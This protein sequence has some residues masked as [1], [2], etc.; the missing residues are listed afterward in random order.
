MFL[1]YHE[2]GWIR[3]NSYGSLLY[4]KR[5][6]DYIFAVFEIKDYA[7]SF[8]NYISRQHSNIK[9]TMQTQKDG[10]LPRFLSPQQA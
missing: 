9:F 5:Y 7:D 6:V 10:K 3:D 4:Y 1:R 2:K 8:Y